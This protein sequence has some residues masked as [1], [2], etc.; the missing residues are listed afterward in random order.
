MIQTNTMDRELTWPRRSVLKGLAAA[1]VVAG[2]AT[3]LGAYHGSQLASRRPLEPTP[4]TVDFVLY[5]GADGLYGG[6][7]PAPDA[8]M[9][10]PMG[11]FGFPALPAATGTDAGGEKFDSTEATVSADGETAWYAL[12]FGG[13][14]TP[15]R[16]RHQGAG[17]YH[18]QDAVVTFEWTA[19]ERFALPFFTVGEVYQAAVRD[20]VQ[21]YE[22]GGAFDW[23][24]TRADFMHTATGDHVAS[25]LTI[26][27]DRDGPENGVARERGSPG[28]SMTHAAGPSQPV[29]PA[30]VTP[31]VGGLTIREA[32]DYLVRSGISTDGVV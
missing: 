14:R 5:A 29:F 19:D 31:T 17:T 32:V 1:A 10:D 25:V 8:D 20:I 4:S 7:N 9:V 30:E 16:L 18:S 26:V 28:R 24:A 21:L 27:W 23:S 3:A 2:A 15:Y 13:R 12:T 11:D 22:P 6:D